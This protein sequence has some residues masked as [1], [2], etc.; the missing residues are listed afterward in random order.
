MNIIL[1]NNVE[2]KIDNSEVRWCL[3]D[4]SIWIGK[5]KNFYEVESIIKE[6]Y[7]SFAWLASDDETLLFDKKNLI[8]RS[9]VIKIYEPIQVIEDYLNYEDIRKEE[10]NIELGQTGFFNCTIYG[11]TKYYSKE[12]ILVV[13]KYNS[14]NKE[15]IA[16][17]ITN[18]FSFIIKSNELVGWILKNSSSHI[19]PAKYGGT[20]IPVEYSEYTRNLLTKYLRLVNQLD[21][22]FIDNEKLIM[23]LEELYSSVGNY[24]KVNIMSIKDNI[25]NIIDIIR[26][27][28]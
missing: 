7:G 3:H 12:D 18:D 25:P 13:N 10:G 20:D 26:K 17:S 21:M 1:S 5:E 28:Y 2:K 4:Q 11:Y 23:D 9:G 19:A 16:I 24:T 14:P 22:D 27:F 15:I 8:F 6:C